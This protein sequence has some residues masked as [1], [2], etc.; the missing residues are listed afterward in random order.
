MHSIVGACL[1]L[2]PILAAAAEPVDERAALAQRRQAVEQAFQAAQAECA[3][4]FAV[5]SC[6]ATARLKR[7]DEWVALQKAEAA[8]DARER[9]AVS[10]RRA[11]VVAPTAPQLPVRAPAAAASAASRVRAPALPASGSLHA[12]PPASAGV[13]DRAAAER[14][15]RAAYEQRQRDAELRR[16]KVEQRQAE[17]PSKAAP[18]P[19]PPSVSG[20]AR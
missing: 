18:L 1:W 8:L 7:R 10:Q 5:S 11:A 17:R 13:L 15:A 19:I 16:R 20:A 4:R 9:R 6:L 14:R 2:L 3:T 12:L